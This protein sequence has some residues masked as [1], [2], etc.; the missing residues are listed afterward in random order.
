MV[1]TVLFNKYIKRVYAEDPYTVVIELL[2]PASKFYEYFVNVVSFGSILIMPKH[3]FEKVEDPLRFPFF[4]PIGTSPY[5]LIDYDPQGYWF[6]FERREDWYRTGIGR[7]FGKPK[8]KYILR[9]FLGG[10]EK[11]IIVFA[12]HELDFSEIGFPSIE[13]AKKASPYVRGW[14]KTFPHSWSEVCSPGVMIKPLGEVA[15]GLYHRWVN[16]K[17]MNCSIRWVCFH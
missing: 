14:W 4:P 3:I 9:I 5:V 15:T 17:S 2:E 7:T 8:P 13:A 16:E 6:L 1:N 11:E 12:K 10:D